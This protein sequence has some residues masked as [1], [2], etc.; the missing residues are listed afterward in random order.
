METFA[1]VFSCEH[2]VRGWGT[3]DGEKAVLK[4]GV[5]ITTMLIARTRIAMRV[6]MVGCDERRWRWR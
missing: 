2:L 6:I 4:L 5:A 1:K 3:D